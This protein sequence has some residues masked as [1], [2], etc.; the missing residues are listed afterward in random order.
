MKRDDLLL[1]LLLKSYTRERLRHAAD[2]HNIKKGRNKKDT[3]IN[4]IKSRK[5]KYE[6]RIKWF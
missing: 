5:V 2:F 3:A 1:E 4:I 6:L